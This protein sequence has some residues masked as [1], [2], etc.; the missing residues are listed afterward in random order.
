MDL[1]G[2]EGPLGSVR[3][4]V[5][6][7]QAAPGAEVGLQPI[8]GAGQGSEYDGG[9]G[10]LVDQSGATIFSGSLN[11]P[12]FDPAVYQLQDVGNG[13]AAYPQDFTLFIVPPTLDDIFLL[14]IHRT[15]VRLSY[16]NT[17]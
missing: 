2:A 14:S 10:L 11:A 8:Q 17:S 5:H 16:R 3:T 9:N 4:P 6:Q 13:L 15:N 7:H 1:L 12:T